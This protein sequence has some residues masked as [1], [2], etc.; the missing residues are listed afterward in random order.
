M[1]N[2]IAELGNTHEGS[3]GLAKAMIEAAKEAGATHVKVQTHFFEFE[4]TPDAP[5]PPYFSEESRKDYF[6]RTSFGKKEFLELLNFSKHIGIELFSSPFSKQAVEFLADCGVALLKIPSGEVT[7]IPLLRCA[8]ATKLPLILS[9]G[10][11][12]W[13]ELDEAV[14]EIEASNGNLECIMQCTSMYPTQAKCVGLNNLSELQNRYDGRCSTIGF[15]DH[16]HGISASL[17]ALVLGSDWI[18]KHFT[19]STLMY[20]SDA[21]NSMEPEKFKEYCG[22]IYFLQEALNSPVN[23]DE[24]VN[25]LK[26]MKRI[27]EKSLYI[28]ETLCPGDVISVE[29]LVCLKP[30]DGISAS[31]YDEFL[32]KI[33][34]KNIP[35]NTLLREEDLN[36]D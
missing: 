14:H 16:T 29:N 35:Q 23:K 6:E 31:R 18:E 36:G 3:I 13:A 8:A 4:S 30:N 12:S 9:S 33:V 2:I 20:G 24:L 27:F 25:E 1:V 22:E 17:A 32:G 10:M 19:L 21:K 11:S 5:N 28:S 15:S 34:R 7:N 26:D